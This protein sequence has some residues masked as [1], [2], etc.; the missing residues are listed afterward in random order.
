MDGLRLLDTAY[1][2]FHNPL[3]KGGLGKG[4]YLI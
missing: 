2:P 4:T 1:H 3:N